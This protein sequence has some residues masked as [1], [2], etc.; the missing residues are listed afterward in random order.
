[1]RFD[2]LAHHPFP[3]GPPRRHAVNPDDVVVP[4]MGKLTA[5]LAVALRAGNVYPRQR[6][7]IW[8]TEISWDSKPPDPNGIPANLHARYLEGALSELWSQGV[9]TVL[10]YNLRDEAEGPGWQFT[11]QSGLYLRGQTVA[12][13]VRKPAFAAFLFPFTAYLHRGVAQLWGLAPGAGTVVVEAKN[14]SRW[15]P[16]ARLHAGT[17]RLFLG[18]KR[19]RA[20][21]Q[22]RARE[23][24]QTSLTWSSFSP[25]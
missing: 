24:T 22:L 6:K 25:S 2:A 20:G 18:H 4:D 11:L 3:I 15:K 17:N 23:G 19:V 7:Q 21:T 5:P 10:W 9:D 12:Q 14:G 13:D 16:I 8:A 1:V